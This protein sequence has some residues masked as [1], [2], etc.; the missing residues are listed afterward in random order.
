MKEKVRRQPFHSGESGQNPNSRGIR[1]CERLGCELSRADV[2]H[3]KS[4]HRQRT[5]NIAVAVDVKS[6]FGLWRI[7]LQQFLYG[8][9]QVFLLLFGLG[10]GIE[11]FAR[12]TAPREILVR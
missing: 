4:A 2:R 5:R 10:F 3:V 11:S 7:V 9:C 8:L 1:R 12:Y 6:L